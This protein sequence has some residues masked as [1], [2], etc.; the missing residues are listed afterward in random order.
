MSM[1]LPNT[2]VGPIGAEGGEFIDHPATMEEL[3]RDAELAPVAT[4][5]RAID[6]DGA[7]AGGRAVPW[8]QGDLHPRDRR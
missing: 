8:R 1:Y 7:E 6:V 2:D 4:V 3:G 5:G